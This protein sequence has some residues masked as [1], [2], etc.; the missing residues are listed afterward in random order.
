MDLTLIIPTFNR[1]DYLNRALRY[2]DA[3]KFS[4]AILIGDSSDDMAEKKI[5][6]SL[7]EQYPNLNIKYQYFNLEGS[8]PQHAAIKM[9][10]LSDE[11]KTS[12]V[13]FAGDDDFQIPNGLMQCVR[14]LDKN[15]D[16]VAAH[17]LRYN[18][19]LDNAVYGNIIEI[20]ANEG[21]SWD[22]DNPV[23]RWHNYMECGIATVFY[24]HRTPIWKKCFAYSLKA[25]ADYI[26]NEL[27][28]CSLCAIL[29]KVKK[30]DCPTTI[31]QRNTPNKIFSFRDITLWDL[32]N[33]KYW[34]QS[35]KVYEKAVSLELSA[36]MPIE[37]AK[38]IFYREFWYHCLLIMNSQ[39]TTK[40]SEKKSETTRPPID[41][42]GITKKNDFFLVH[43][44]LKGG[45]K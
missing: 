44:I 37:E 8:N 43:K 33:G 2:Y 14:F 15:P 26:G 6:R 11:I 16:Y 36:Y 24:V 3:A 34:A 5:N 10:F 45:A 13:A 27:I 35:V 39:F 41:F 7:V 38:K 32:I 17:G 30:L 25:K 21:Y 28:Q 31:F 12:Y 42:S 29:G 9:F 1:S 23:E 4:G 22:T 18:F 19:T 20:D 40:Y